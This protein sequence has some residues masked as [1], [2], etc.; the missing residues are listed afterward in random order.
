[1]Y[2][3]ISSASKDFLDWCKLSCQILGMRQLNEPNSLQGHMWGL[4]S[5]RP[6]N[7]AILVNSIYK[8]SLGMKRKEQK[9]KDH[10]YKYTLAA[11]SSNW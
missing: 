4:A 6:E 9:L 3:N 7:L 2:F 11:L 10:F 5:G 8:G 1:M